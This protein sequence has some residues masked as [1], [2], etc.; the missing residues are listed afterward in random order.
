LRAQKGRFLSLFFQ[1][2][3]PPAMQLNTNKTIESNFD[4]TIERV[5]E[6]LKTIGF[7]LDSVINV[8]ATL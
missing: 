8:S 5:T 6:Q 3:T 2:L 4:Q 7:S 1:I